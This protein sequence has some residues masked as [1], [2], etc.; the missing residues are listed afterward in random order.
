MVQ[1]GLTFLSN[2]TRWHHG[3]PP[4]AARV[5]SGGGK[6]VLDTA[7]DLE[8]ELARAAEDIATKRRRSRTRA[9]RT[10]AK[11]ATL[12]ASHKAT[13]L[14]EQVTAKT[15]SANKKHRGE[16]TS[17]KAADH[18]LHEW[19]PIWDGSPTDG[20]EAIARTVEAIYA[21]GRKEDEEEELLLPPINPERLS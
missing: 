4:G 2:L 11:A 6:D 13:K 3:R 18:G 5:Y 10:W 17:Q 21:I 8:K 20:G 9:C 1:R 19:A 16:T 15:A 12:A 7:I 14:G